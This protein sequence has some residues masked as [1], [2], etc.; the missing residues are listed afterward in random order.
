MI[1]NDHIE[2]RKN[3]SDPLE[4]DQFD[5]QTAHIQIYMTFG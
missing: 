4:W 3:K 2:L 5:T 1:Q